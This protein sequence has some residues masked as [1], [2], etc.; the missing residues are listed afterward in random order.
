MS[1]GVDVERFRP[2]SPPPVFRA[3]FVGALIKRKG[4]HLLLEAWKK[5]NL[6]KAELWLAGHPH[7]ELVPYLAGLPDSVKI[8]GFSNRVEE[9]YRECSLFVFPS[10]CRGKCESYLRSGGV[11]FRHR[12]RRGNPEMWWSMERMG[13]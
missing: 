5:L 4:V 2:G 12:S 3:L 8:L 6:P 9:L 7:S 1:R 11:R 13:F 10:E